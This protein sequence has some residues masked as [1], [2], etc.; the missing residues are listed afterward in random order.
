MSVVKCSGPSDAEVAF[1]GEAPG[2]QEAKMGLGFVGPSG[3]EL[4]ALSPWPR[5]ACHVN[6]LVKEFI[7]GNPDPT[8]A[9]IDFWGP[10]LEQDLAKVC[11]DLIVAVGRFAATWFLGSYNPE[12]DRGDLH[13]VRRPWGTP[14]VIPITHPAA[15]FHDPTRYQWFVE[16]MAQV[17]K[18]HEGTLQKPRERQLGSYQWYTGGLLIGEPYDA[19]DTEFDR[20]GLISIQVSQMPGEGLVL[21]P[22][23][24][25]RWGSPL[26][27]H[28]ALADA[29]LL[30]YQL[31]ADNFEDTLLMAR[32]LQGTGGNGL[33]TLAWRMCRLKLKSFTDV[34]DPYDNRVVR[35]WLAAMEAE[36]EPVYQERISEKTG[37][38]L[39]PKKLPDA[40]WVKCVRRAIKSDN[41]RKLW[42]DQSKRNPEA[43]D[44]CP[45]D[46][47]PM[48]LRCVP[49]DE[50]LAYAGADADVTGRLFPLLRDR[51]GR[52][53]LGRAYETAK[54]AFPVLQRIQDR[55]ILT[56]PAHFNAL[57]DE[58]DYIIAHYMDK[59]HSF[60]DVPEEFSP[61]SP[62]KT[63]ELVYGILDL[64]PRG[65]V[66]RMANG[67]P[68]SDDAFL[69]ALKDP[70]P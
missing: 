10:I 42:D 39:K 27:F 49:D 56:N 61:T 8:D 18:W 66:K 58:L 57:T 32:L 30:G 31:S 33:K 68:S 59:I 36:F 43:H 6:N 60:P 24:P 62:L 48:S 44:N 54:G 45:D 63:S 14:M 1:V 22:D 29:S 2:R 20:D 65:R 70:G 12:R 15:G 19:V 55:G 16:D 46:M 4:W 21:K 26:V 41:P 17:R 23:Q 5:A 47:P 7:E 9:Q 11:P 67:W 52:M 69:Q 28:N 64:K 38:V 40:N 3:D 13:Q 51:V 37:K 25:I 53:G 50:F 35:D 34:I